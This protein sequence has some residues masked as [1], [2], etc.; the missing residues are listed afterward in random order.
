MKKVKV[1][2]AGYGVVGQ[3][4]ADAVVMQEDMELV[5]IVD[6]ELN[7]GLRALKERGMPYK[8]F[9]ADPGKVGVLEEA[10]FPV[11]GIFED[12]LKGVDVILDATPHGVG[13]ENKKL[14]KKYGV[15]GIFQAGEKTEIVDL[16]FHSYVNY[17]KGIGKDFLKVPSCNTTGLIR[18]INTLDRAVGIE[19]VAITIFRRAIDPGKT[20][21][22]VVDLLMMEPIP[23][24]QVVDLL[25]IMPHVKGTGLLVHTPVTHGHINIIVATPKKRITKEKILEEFQKDPRI[26]VVRIKDG[27]N[28]NTALFNYGRFLGHPRGDMYDIAVFEETIGFSGDDIMFAINIPQE[29]VVTPETVDAIR[30]SMKMQTDLHEAIRITNKYLGLGG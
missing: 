9:W 13:A 19:K 15:K 12:M 14:Y 20:Q 2:V 26:R 4:L 17:E 3:R 22:G 8:L 6:I 23:N 11:S 25:T 7:L 10:G 24:N 5:G 18:A 30:A 16:F 21:W 29:S 1:G 28:S 27:F